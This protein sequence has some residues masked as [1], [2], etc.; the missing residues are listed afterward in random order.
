M[1][2]IICDVCGSAYPETSNQCPICGYV[3]P[4]E[5]VASGSRSSQDNGTRTYTHVKGGRFS[6][7]NVK[8]RNRAKQTAVSYAPAST[9]SRRSK[10]QK[11]KSNTG[12]VITAIILLL[13]IAV[14]ALYLVRTYFWP[15]P[16]QEN[17]T[18]NT[19]QPAN[20][21]TE[22][23]DPTKSEIKCESLLLDVGEVRLQEIGTARMIYVTVSPA[24]T[25]DKI[26]YES[27]DE[28][29]VTVTEHGKLVAV[30]PGEATITI[31]CGEIQTTCDVFCDIEV[32]SEDT[33]E[34]PT[35]DTTE[36]E[37]RL[38]RED[39]TF[40]F[41]GEKWMLYSGDIPKSQITWT[42]NNES[43]AIISYG[44]VEAVGPGTTMVYAEYNG[45][46]VGCIIRCAFSDSEY[47]G[48]GGHGGVGED[49]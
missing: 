38:N 26:V 44:T 20:I 29:V 5:S 23:I 19:D 49:G 1:S 39:I 14:V 2:K 6:K 36:E 42:S 31:T 47:E 18:V 12:L 27:S 25:T 33:T 43:V 4:A 24:N 40:S 9:A 41:A 45:I 34:A 11:K 46:K 13:A 8:K 32:P 22:P 3:R 10:P 7:A 28:A 21:Q 48:V 17:P 37:F 16:Q 30:G 15:N 35:E